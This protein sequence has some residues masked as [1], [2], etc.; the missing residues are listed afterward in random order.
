MSVFLIIVR[1][2]D[3]FKISL[4]SKISKSL[5]TIEEVWT[6]T[7]PG[8]ILDDPNKSFEFSGYQEG[9]GRIIGR[10][11][12]DKMVYANA[13]VNPISIIFINDTFFS[14]HLSIAANLVLKKL[15]GM[16]NKKYNERSVTGLLMAPNPNILDITGP[17]GYLSSWVFMLQGVP[18]DLL[19]TKL[20]DEKITFEYFK[21]YGENTLAESYKDFITTWLQP[22]SYFKGWYKAH[23]SIPTP[24][25]EIDR[26]RYTIYLEHNLA[27]FL[28]SQDFRVRSVFE[29]LSVFDSMKCKLVLLLDR[30]YLNIIKLKNRIFMYYF[31]D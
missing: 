1:Y 28:Q 13:K 3:E 6:N 9:L 22:K 19:N 17:I 21:D 12:A 31:S 4:P 25:N 24:K 8:Y 27:K 20:Y 30:I 14:T 2:K 29:R 23:P 26:K 5:S 7:S 16:G 11:R 15:V 18:N 10:L